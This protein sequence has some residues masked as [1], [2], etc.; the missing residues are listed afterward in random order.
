M[1]QPVWSLLSVH[2]IGHPGLTETPRDQMLVVFHSMK[3]WGKKA[4]VVFLDKP[5]FKFFLFVCF[6]SLLL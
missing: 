5:A 2:I 6:L 1:G 4:K 3:G